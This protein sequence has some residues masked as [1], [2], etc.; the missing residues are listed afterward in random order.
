[1]AAENFSAWLPEEVGGDVISKV[2]QIS[3]AE[4]LF[5]AEPMGS[6]T[7]RVLREGDAG[8][9]VVSPSTAYGEESS[10]YDYVTL[11]AIKSGRL[12]RVTEEDLADLSTVA[13]VI[14]R[15]KVAWARAYAP[16]IDN[17]TLGVTAAANGT[18]VPYTSLFRS[19]TQTNVATGY[20]AN[21]NII[22]T[23]GALTYGDLDDAATLV[24]DSEQ[25][26]ESMMSWVGSP[27][28]KSSLRKVYNSDGDPMFLDSGAWPDGTV[29]PTLF[30]FPL[31]WSR[32]AR[33]SATVDK[34]P[35]GDPLL[36]LGNWDYA[37]LGK[38]SGPE[39]AVNSAGGAGFET[40]DALLKVRIRR[41]YATA[42]EQ[43]FA[44]IRVTAGS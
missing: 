19:L 7:K 44:C 22:N 20:V 14:A 27:R 10:T 42:Y 4:S 12:M 2:N 29:G 28:I 5:R 43:A 17:A 8:N 15:K 9:A 41:A 26:E 40:D 21:A 1:V 34:S 38:R 23:A 39:S 3:V 37:I 25:F 13:D 32:G 35:T 24:E 36:F 18:T 6:L 16:W 31:K 30:G 33:T 11:T